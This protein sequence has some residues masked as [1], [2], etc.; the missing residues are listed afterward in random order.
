MDGANFSELDSLHE[1]ESTNKFGK[2]NNLDRDSKNTINKV[3]NINK[4]ESVEFWDDIEEDRFISYPETKVERMSFKEMKNKNNFSKKPTIEDELDKD[5]KLNLHKQKKFSDKYLIH[6]KSNQK[7]SEFECIN[8]D[9]DDF[10]GGKNNSIIKFEN[11]NIQDNYEKR[12]NIEED[13]FPT[14]TEQSFG[15]SKKKKKLGINH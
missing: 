1:S 2:L 14:V 10:I 11:K 13:Y 3:I 9:Y 8:L 12:N 5:S 4:R 15:I 7:N 6:I